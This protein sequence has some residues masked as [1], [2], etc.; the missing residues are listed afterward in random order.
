MLKYTL[1]TVQCKHWWNSLAV[2]YSGWIRYTILPQVGEVVRSGQDYA[3]YLRPSPDLCGHGGTDQDP[4][5][6]ADHKAANLHVQHHRPV[7][8]AL[9]WSRASRRRKKC[10][11]TCA[12]GVDCPYKSL[13]GCCTQMETHTWGT[14]K[15]LNVVC[16]HHHM[17]CLE[18]WFCCL[19]K[20]TLGMCLLLV[21]ASTSMGSVLCII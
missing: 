13:L 3:V 9:P 2:R 15:R 5:S 8:H 14:H 1:L 6:Y 20:V 16:V 21:W 18:L 12:S 11:D 19:V 7:T 4:P 10:V 17:F